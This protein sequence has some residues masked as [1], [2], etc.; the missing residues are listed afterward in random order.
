MTSRL[1]ITSSLEDQVDASKTSDSAEPAKKATGVR[2]LAA[3]I[4]FSKTYSFVLWFIFSGALLGFVLA[5]S[6]YLNFY[7]VFCS[8]GGS[9]ASQLHAAPGECY[10]Y[11]NFDRYYVGI[12][13][14]LFAI[15]LASFLVLFQ[16]VPAIRHKFRLFHR[17][18]GYLVVLLVLVSHAGAIMIAKVAFGGTLATQMWVGTLAIVTT[19]A[20][21]L[22]WVNIKRL[23]IDQ[24]RAWMLRAWFYVRI[25]SFLHAIGSTKR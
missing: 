18:N 4:G 8:G 5:R 20:L 11:L 17:I 7:G 9:A 23:Q 6:A 15:I 1:D 10:Y 3:S 22:A 12:R 24:H 19:L 16:F 13:I 2:R 25:S 21:V 14:H